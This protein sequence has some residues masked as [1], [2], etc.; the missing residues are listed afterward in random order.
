VVERRLNFSIARRFADRSNFVFLDES[1]AKT[2]MTRL[3][4]R[5]PKNE[6]CVD[7][8]PC[9]R[10]KTMTMLSAI[11]LDGVV[12]DATWLIDGPMDSHLFLN[13]I[14]QSLAPS[15]KPGD[16]VVMDNLSSHKVNGVRQAIEAVGADLWYLPAYSPDLN[17]IEKLW[18][19]VKSWLRRAT[20]RTFD[21]VCQALGEALR[22]VTPEECSNY[23]T[24]CGYGEH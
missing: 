11:R 22:S 12:E 24:S 15:L 4:G 19:K 5:A 14:E 6:R 9:G 7:R 23:F 13:Y 21:A 2:N 18:S 8:V 20:A 16:I 17:P 10:W 1:G 3:Y